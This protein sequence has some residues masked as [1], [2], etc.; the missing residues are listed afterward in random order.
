MRIDL[1]PSCFWMQ[2]FSQYISDRLIGYSAF[3]HN[4]GSNSWRFPL[5]RARQYVFCSHAPWRDSGLSYR[6]AWLLLVAITPLTSAK[7]EGFSDFVRTLG[8]SINLKRWIGQCRV[9]WSFDSSHCPFAIVTNIGC[10]VLFGRCF[11]VCGVVSF[12]IFM[13]CFHNIPSVKSSVSFDRS[14]A[15]HWCPLSIMLMLHLTRL[16]SA[17]KL[18]HV[19]LHC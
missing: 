2:A 18:L 13:I 16:T 15:S 8:V 17:V 7:G 3:W 12:S 19:H 4:R 9:R 10:L 1:T 14:Q 6:I 11:R 5:F